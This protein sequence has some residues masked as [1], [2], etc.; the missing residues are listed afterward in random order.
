MGFFSSL[1]LIGF[2]LENNTIPHNVSNK[3]RIEG[4][5]FDLEQMGNQ[6]KVNPFNVNLLQLIHKHFFEVVITLV[7]RVTSLFKYLS[8]IGNR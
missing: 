1:L 5:R 2:C 8:L 3:K 4:K 6:M 7:C